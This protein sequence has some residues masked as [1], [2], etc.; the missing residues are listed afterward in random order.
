MSHAGT[1]DQAA[2]VCDRFERE[3]LLHLEQG[4]PL[5]THFD[6]CADCRAARAEHERLRA[7]LAGMAHAHTGRADWQARVWAGL[8]RR[9]ARRRRRWAWL[10]APAAL[11]AAGA[12]AALL[13]IGRP[14]PEGPPLVFT[15]QRPHQGA[16]PLRSDHA[17]PGDTLAVRAVVGGAHGELRLYRDDRALVLRCSDEAPCTRDADLLLASVPLDERGRYQIVFLH[18]D[19]PLPAPTG[20]LDRDIADARAAGATVELRELDVL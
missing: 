1:D 10:V 3:G 13:L 6:T 4:L 11:A 5:D 8:E 20:E 7:G 16:A 17:Q 19:R 12:A 9:Q 15:I 14:G 2:A 18:A